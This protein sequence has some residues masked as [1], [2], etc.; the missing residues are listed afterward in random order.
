MR[1]VILTVGP[2]GAGKSHF[3]EA[4]VQYDPSLQYVSRDAILVERCGGTMFDPYLGLHWAALEEGWHRVATHLASSP[5]VRVIFD[6]WN[7]DPRERRDIL[8]RLREM[9]AE[10]VVVWYFITPAEFV[11]RWFWLKPDVAKSSEMQTCHRRGVV[12]MADDAATRDYYYFHWLAAEI[13]H[14]GFDAVVRINPVVMTAEQVLQ[15]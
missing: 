4:A 8:Y 10:R 6:T 12:F 13:D 3:C 2:R 9:G 15:A 14:E 1:E 5:S 11:E 7:M